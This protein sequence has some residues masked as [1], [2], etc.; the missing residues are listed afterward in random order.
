MAYSREG[1]NAHVR[2]YFDTR[3]NSTFVQRN[4]LLYMLG[5]RSAEGRT[6]LGQPKAGALFGGKNLGSAQVKEM[7]GSKEIYHTYVKEEPNDGG[8]VDFGGNAKT[9][10]AFAEDNA[11]QIRFR[12]THQQ[13]P[14]KIRQH[15]LFFAKG[16]SGIGDIVERA[17]DPV[18]TRF[19]KRINTLL[20]YGGTGANGSAVNMNSLS[21]QNREIWREPLG[22]KYAIG[23]QSN[24][25]G[26]TDRSS[27]TLLNPFLINA[28]TAFSTTIVDLDINRKVN[29]GY[30]N[31]ATSAAV[32]GV[33]NKDEAGVGCKLFITTPVLF[34]ELAAQADARGIN[35]RNGLEGHSVT[36]F[37]YS[38]IEHDNVFYT[39]DKDCPSGTMY[40]LNLDTVLVEVASGMN[41]K[42]NGFRDKSMLE[43]GGAKYEYGEYET[44]LRLSVTKPWLSGSVVGLTAA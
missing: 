39:W 6:K 9:A 20:W 24:I 36:G 11:G 44:M 28:A 14:L 27:E 31:A 35:V 33:A 42:W 23:T 18:W 30:I 34:N 7:A 25:Y 10:T 12:W 19:Q 2:E 40:C 3:L 26:G 4:P 17:A 15:S 43:E 38:V 5:F 13:E 41:F 22:L 8:Y 21:E 32:D 37:E 1:I 16:E 29:N